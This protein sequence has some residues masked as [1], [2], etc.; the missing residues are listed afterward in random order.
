MTSRYYKN[1]GQEEHGIDDWLMTYADMITL[2][3]CFFA[4]FLSV[5]VPKKAEFEQA[6]QKVLEKFASPNSPEGIF[7]PTALPRGDVDPIESS[8]PVNP[9]VM[10]G[11]P[12]EAIPLTGYP[13]IVGN[14]VDMGEEAAPKQ[15]GDRITTIDLNSAPFFASGSSTLSDEGKTLLEPVIEKVN[16]DRFRNYQITIEGHTDDSPINTLQFPSN[17]ELSTGRAASVVRYFMEQGIP[18]Q[19]LRASGYAD[20]FPKMPNRDDAGN[21]IP[22]NQ[23]QNR[24]VVIK[25]ERIRKAE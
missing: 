12:M 25:L 18:A 13:S 22:E 17:W 24:R 20:T 2:L 5:S 19:R 15:I 4:I 16:S 1:R 14:L 7:A 21:P 6:R 3:L 11:R 8:P 9:D 10:R 23:A